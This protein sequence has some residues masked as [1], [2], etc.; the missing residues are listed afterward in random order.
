MTTTKRRSKK[1]ETETQTFEEPELSE[2]LD[3]IKNLADLALEKAE[4]KRWKNKRKPRRQ[5]VGK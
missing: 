1:P 2:L 3:Y 4:Q 5:L